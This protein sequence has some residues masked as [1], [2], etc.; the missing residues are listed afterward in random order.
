MAEY[1]DK[2]GEPL[3]PMAYENRISNS[4]HEVLFSLSNLVY[5]SFGLEY[6]FFF[7][8]KVK[9]ILAYISQLHMITCFNFSASI[10]LLWEFCLFQSYSPC[11]IERQWSHH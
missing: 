3:V 7:F 2:G 9:L 8:I 1:R 10:F 11:Y 4:S 5:M 6:F